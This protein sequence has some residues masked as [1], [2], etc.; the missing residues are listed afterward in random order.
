MFF[1]FYLKV[2]Y[3][4]EYHWKVGYYAGLIVESNDKLSQ[5]NEA[6]CQESL[7][8]A[9]EAVTV[10]QW[11]RISDHVGRKPVLLVGLAGSALS[12]I[13]FGISR[14]FLTLI[15]R[16][17]LVTLFTL[18]TECRVSRCLCGALNGNVGKYMLYYHYFTIMDEIIG[19]M[20]SVMG[21]ILDTTNRAEGF[22][23]LPVVLSA[24]ATIA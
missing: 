16:W 6:T 22:S 18:W 4:V 13:C 19:V 15:I 1:Y 9:A 21:E 7:Y 23:L 20:K 5:C 10:L 17:V 12:M 3:G 2:N 14:T 11:G 8:Y 24:G